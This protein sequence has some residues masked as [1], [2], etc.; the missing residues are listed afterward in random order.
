M[1]TKGK[2]R[3][4]REVAWTSARRLPAFRPPGANRQASNRR[5]GPRRRHGQPR[6]LLPSAKSS[7]PRRQL[8]ARASGQARHPPFEHHG[9]DEVAPAG[10]PLDGHPGQPWPP[11]RVSRSFTAH[12]T[13]SSAALGAGRQHESTTQ[14]V[15]LGDEA[16]RA[17][18]SRL[19]GIDHVQR[20]R[21]KRARPAGKVEQLAVLGEDQATRADGL[22]AQLTDRILG[23]H[24]RTGRGERP[25][26]LRS[27]G[28]REGAGFSTARVSSTAPASAAISASAH[29]GPS[30]AEPFLDNSSPL[31]RPVVPILKALA[32]QSSAMPRLVSD[33][34]SRL[35]PFVGARRLCP[36]L[37]R[38]PGRRR[39]LV[40]I[41][42]PGLAI[43]RRVGTRA[44]AVCRR[45][46][47]VPT[48]PVTAADYHRRSGALDMRCR[49]DLEP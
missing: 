14:A 10:P 7:N 41:R 43:G 32:F 1:M 35:V 28:R 5:G 13:R 40:P 34:L 8:P 44:R 6:L 20:S 22:R 18:L 17:C 25:N 16:R 19:G 24:G 26:H 4:P 27:A 45:G 48:L 47:R 46:L 23:G 2:G 49:S 38:V 39:G 31:R 42:R 37:I 15:G 30:F 21:S 9:L 36:R 33:R 12:R 11:V 29:V 3:E